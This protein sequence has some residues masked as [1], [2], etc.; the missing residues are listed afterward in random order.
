M[1]TSATHT[2]G[3]LVIGNIYSWMASLDEDMAVKL[4]LDGLNWMA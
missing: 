2:L 3:P 4:Q 1:R